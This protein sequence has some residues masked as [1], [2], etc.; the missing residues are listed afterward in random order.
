[1]ESRENEVVEV[2]G[3]EEGV[4]ES[5][6]NF[7]RLRLDLYLRLYTYRS[8][9]N[10]SITAAPNEIV[11]YRLGHERCGGRDDVSIS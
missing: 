3:D 9:Q 10:D 8:A 6:K 7:A 4:G 5:A 11:P 1:M 2:E